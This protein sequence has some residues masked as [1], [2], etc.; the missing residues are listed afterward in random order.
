MDLT[1]IRQGYKDKGLDKEDLNTDPIIQFE[2]WFEE[3]K[4]S[5]PIPTAMSLSTVNSDG[6]PTSVSYTH[7]TLPTIYSV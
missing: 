3:A 2:S 1:F 7:L 4:K 5:E 6:E